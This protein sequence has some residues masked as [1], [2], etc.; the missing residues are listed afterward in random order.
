MK[1][2]Y[3]IGEYKHYT[4]CR[5]CGAPDLQLVIQLGDMPL[6]GGFF[7]AGTSN[8]KLEQE[9][10]YPL[11]ICFCEQCYLLQVNNIVNP[12]LLFKNYFYHTSAIKTLT[13]HFTE[14]A[15][16]LPQKL[17]PKDSF[18]VEIGS[19]DGPFIKALQK[20]HFRCIGVDPAHNIVTTARK[21]GLPIIEAYFTTKVAKEIVKEH[22]QADAIFSFNTMAHIEDMHE[23]VKGIKLLLKP[24][25]FLTFE[26]HYL[27]SVLAQTQYDML[28]HEHQYYYSVLTLQKLFALHDMEIFDVELVTTHAGSLRVSVQHIKTGK[29]K[30]SDRLHQFIAEEKKAG[31]DKIQTYQNFNAQIEKTKKDLLKLLNKLK[32]DGKKI[33]GYGASGRG[34]ILSNYCGL[35]SHYLEYVIDDAPAKQGAITPGNHLAIQSS[36]VLNTSD[37]PDYCVLF[38]WSFWEEIRAKNTE[39]SKRG[40]KFIVPLPEVRIA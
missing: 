39:Y 37:R 26:I 36:A 22:G 9:R 34:T 10:S 1:K 5:F 13:D 29:E 30:L 31:Y 17:N 14:L 15:D 2:P 27:R 11:D 20:N 6:A 16:S 40:G 19:N 28:Y 12:D 18:I 32:A 38:A 35:D 33:V 7:P 8:K 24:N 21:E 23:V 25:G 3:W 4:F